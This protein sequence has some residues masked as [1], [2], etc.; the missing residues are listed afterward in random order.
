MMDI[1]A[2]LQ[3]LQPHVTTTTHRRLNRITLALLV[4]TG[5][6]MMLGLACWAGKGGSYRTVQRFFTTGLPWA[7][8]FWVFFRQHVYSQEEGYLL[9]GDEVVVTKAGKITHGLD[10]F[11]S[12]L[13]SKPVP[14]V[15]R[16]NSILIALDVNR[17]SKDN[18]Q[19]SQ[20]CCRGTL[21]P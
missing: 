9:V 6:I 8:L 12:S 18:S 17:R 19:G 11:F 4:M 20:P 7:M 21:W 16:N 1:V 3:C 14:G 13:C 15:L 10:R 2:L 5:R